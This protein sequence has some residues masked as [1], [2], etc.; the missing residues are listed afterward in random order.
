MDQAWKD[1]TYNKLRVSKNQNKS[2]RDEIV[3]LR[4]KVRTLEK[5]VME[6]TFA[7]S[8]YAAFYEIVRDRALSDQFNG[9][10]DLAR[11]QIKE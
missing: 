11:A 7:S 10:R 3:V 5:T 8:L 4:E 9:W 1:G 2:M 6:D